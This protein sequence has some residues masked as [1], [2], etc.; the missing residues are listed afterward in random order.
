M[1]SFH[2]SKFQIRISV[3][4]LPDRSTLALNDVLRNV[5]DE[6]CVA[7]GDVDDDELFAAFGGTNDDDAFCFAIIYKHSYLC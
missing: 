7:F 6:L 1:Y 3:Y 5:H 4:H 2:R